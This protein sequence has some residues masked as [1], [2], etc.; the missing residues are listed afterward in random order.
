MIK[1]CGRTFVS[2]L[3]VFLLVTSVFTVTGYAALPTISPNKLTY[4][5]KNITFTCGSG[6][7]GTAT[8]STIAVTVNDSDKSVDI[9][10]QT[11]SNT[12]RKLNLIASIPKGYIMH[13]D[14]EIELAEGIKSQFV[15]YTPQGQDA[16]IT[17]PIADNNHYL[18]VCAAASSGTTNSATIGFEVSGKNQHFKAHLRNVDLVKSQNVSVNVTAPQNGSVTVATRP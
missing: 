3:L 18:L 6:T 10:I 15:K 13:F 7:N 11:K 8:D 12:N 17:S 14:Y 2:F 4:G 9:D 16:S 1:K 5:S